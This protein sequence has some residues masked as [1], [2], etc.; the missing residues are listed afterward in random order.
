MSEFPFDASLFSPDP[1][2][3]NGTKPTPRTKG[4]KKG[5]KPLTPGG[6][7]TFHALF[8]L[9]EEMASGKGVPPSRVSEITTFDSGTTGRHFH[10]LE[11]KGYITLNKDGAKYLF[12]TGITP[13]GLNSHYLRFLARKSTPLAPQE[14]TGKIDEDPTPDDAD[15]LTDSFINLGEDVRVEEFEKIKELVKPR[16]WET[17]FDVVKALYDYTHS[18][19][20]K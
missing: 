6:V 15:R 20:V 19:K 2:K 1:P 17:T 14:A 7:S 18:N 9:Q 4:K 3:S 12:V 11:K 13:I 5:V 10:S 8:H 16:P